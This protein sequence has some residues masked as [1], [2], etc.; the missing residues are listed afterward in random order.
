MTKLYEI[1]EQYKELQALAEDETMAEAVADTL[2]GIQGEFDDKA[3]AISSMV[4]NMDGDI[5]PIDSA[6]ARLQARKKVIQNKQESLKNYLRENMTRCDI[7]KIACPLFTV[8]LVQGREI[9]FIDNEEALP[10]DYLSVKTTISPDKTAITKALKEG[11][12]IPG[13]H[14]ERAK[15]SVRI[16]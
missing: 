6:I 5:E 8:T 16:K 4:L 14:L 9:A 15:S 3:K 10:E 2:E 11:V 12:E 7:K 1:S 13:A